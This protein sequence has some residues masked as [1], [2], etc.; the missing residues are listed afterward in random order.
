M[1]ATET[2]PPRSPPGALVLETCLSCQRGRALPPSP[3]PRTTLGVEQESKKDLDLVPVYCTVLMATG[4]DSSSSLSDRYDAE[5]VVGVLEINATS[6]ALF[7]M[8]SPAIPSNNPAWDRKEGIRKWGDPEKSMP[9]DATAITWAI[10]NLK[11]VLTTALGAAIY[12][13]DLE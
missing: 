11:V 10:T 1:T 8:G 12:R 13:K 9:A 3:L 2:P 4:W 7:P 5:Q 6:P